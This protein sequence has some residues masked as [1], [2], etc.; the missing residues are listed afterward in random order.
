M[1]AAAVPLYRLFCNV[2]G[3]GGTTQTNAKSTVPVLARTITVGFNTDVDPS[4]PWEFTPGDKPITAPIGKQILTHF[5]AHNRSTRPVTGRAVYNV[6]P[7]SAGPYFVKIECFCFS[8][9]TLQPGET[10]TMP[11]VFYVDPAMAS[12]PEMKNIQTIT[13]SYTFFPVKK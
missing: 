8:E 13:L 9:Q 2:T 1:T 4:L 6:T 7:F 10:V 11:V 3:Y 12:D 5:I